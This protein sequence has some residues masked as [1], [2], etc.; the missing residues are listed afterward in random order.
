MKRIHDNDL[1]A[2]VGATPRNA[3]K[4]I[5]EQVPQGCKT[6]EPSPNQA[7]P[8]HLPGI[9]VSGLLMIGLLALAV[10]AAPT[11]SRAAS[12]AVGVSVGIAPP[13]I[14]VY[15]QPVCP[16]PGYLWTPG[17]WAY[18]P[19]GGYYWVPGTWVMA[20]APGLLW[21]PGYWGWG[22]AAFVW[23]AGYWGPHVGFYGGINYGFGYLGVGFVGGEWRGGTFFYNRAVTNFGGRRFANAYNRPVANHF[24]ASRVSYNGG[25]GGLRARPTAGELAAEHDRHM[26]ATSGQRQHE[27]AAHNERSQF[28]SVNHGRPAVAAT[29]RPGDFRGAAHANRAASTANHG[30]LRSANSAQAHGNSRSRSPR[31]TAGGNH[32][33]MTARANSSSPH[34]SVRQARRAPG[35]NRSTAPSRNTNSRG[36]ASNRQIASRQQRPQ[37]NASRRSGGGKSKGSD[38]ASHH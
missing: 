28:A 26:Q 14:P 31:R 15:A 34:S 35:N 38:A 7:R 11:T 27:V 24:A 30:G 37:L 33:V 21:T 13:P 32:Q 22:G 6:E 18:D 17:Y 8:Q 36:A 29:G 16:G 19:A 3:N 4:I 12:I 1:P 5:A 9:W 10:F 23:H 25:A 2:S 20:P